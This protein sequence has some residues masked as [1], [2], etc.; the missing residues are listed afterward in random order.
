MNFRTRLAVWFAASLFILAAALLFSAHWHLDEELRQDRWD[1]SHPKYPQWVIHGSYTNEEVHDILGELVHVWLWVGGPLLIGSLAVG[2]LIACRSVRPIR[3]INREL[4]A[5]DPGNLD[6][7]VQL[8]DS[9]PEL[10]AL[11]SHI[12]KLLGR[13]H[14]SYAEMAEFSARVAHELRNPLTHLRMKLEAAAPQLPAEFSEE[15]QEEIYRLS[16]LVER[17]L[18]LAKAENGR[19]DPHIETFSLD[20][21]L[22]DLRESYQ[23]LAD[24]SGCCP[25]WRVSPDL[26]GKGDTG[27]LRQIFHNLL[28]N[29]LRYGRDPV[30]LTAFPQA[31]K[32]KIVFCLTNAIKTGS[33]PGGTGIGLRL[34]RGLCASLPDTRFRYRAHG[35]FFSVRITLPANGSAQRRTSEAS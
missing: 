1:R 13:A 16:Q 28:G 35:G 32:G 14:R 24:G 19:L 5:L 34:V 6:R 18:L 30:R 31:R 21:I 26:V 23:I 20:A 3:Q 25:E 10:S 17:S 11:V 7:G 33:A 15:V 9:D 2:Y 8:P 4:D 27:W 22:E 29:V 12:N